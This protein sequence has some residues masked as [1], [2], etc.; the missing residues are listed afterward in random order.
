MKQY[1]IERLKKEN[2]IVFEAIM[3]SHAYGTNLPTS[4]TN[5]RGIFIQPLDEILGFGKVDQ[6]ADEKNDIIYYEIGRFLDLLKSNNPNILEILNTPAD[7]IR[8]NDEEIMNI[9]FSHKDD[10]LTKK[11]RWSFGGYA[12]EQIKKARGLN[13]KMNWE[14]NEMV[15]KTVLDFCYV[16]ENGGSKPIKEWLNRALYVIGRITQ[17]DF[18][19]AAIDHGHDLYAMYLAPQDHAA[20]WGIVSNEETANDVQLTSI[21]KNI[22]VEGYL[23]FN[24]DAYSS[25]CKKFKEYQEWLNNRN[26]TRVNMAKA[27]GKAYDGKNMNHCVRLLNVANEIAEG[28][29]LNVRRSPEE[30]KKLIAIR[31]GEYEYEDILAEAESLIEKMDKTFEESSL[32]NSVDIDMVNNLLISIRKQWYNLS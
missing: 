1:T 11:C 20:N 16:L 28:K 25:H 26:E 29:G 5:I 24:K 13:K 8:I 21:P 9:I 10:F 2:M 15:R 23:Y 17:K 18:G 14:E 7:C 32:P 6:V 30:I 12:V 27:H 31:K 22:N 3:G 19:L 4:D